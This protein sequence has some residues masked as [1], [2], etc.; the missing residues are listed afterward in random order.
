MI[1]FI[2]LFVRAYH[3]NI[4]N[5]A[6]SWSEVITLPLALRLSHFPIYY[7][8]Y[9]FYLAVNIKYF[10]SMKINGAGSVLRP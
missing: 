9:Y 5:T 3:S 6:P 10:V 4:V 1:R 2:V 8:Y 7:H